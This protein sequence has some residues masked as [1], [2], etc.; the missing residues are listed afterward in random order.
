MSKSTQH[1]MNETENLFN[2]LATLH[3]VKISVTHVSHDERLI[4]IEEPS[5]EQLKALN[6]SVCGRDDIN[7]IRYVFMNKIKVVWK[8][9][10]VIKTLTKAKRRGFLWLSK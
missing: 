7:D 1:F 4:T 2:V 9:K 10:P 5:N 6:F 3:S 8:A